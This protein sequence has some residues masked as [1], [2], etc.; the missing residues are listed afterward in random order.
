MLILC[1]LKKTFKSPT[2]QTLDPETYD[3]YYYSADQP[4]RNNSPDSPYNKKLS[5]LRL[6][7]LNPLSINPIK[8]SNALKQFVGFCGVGA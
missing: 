1:V 7:Y 6:T 4:T 2:R 8:W 5:C 3:Y